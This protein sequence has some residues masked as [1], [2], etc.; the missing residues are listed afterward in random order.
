MDDLSQER[1]SWLPELMDRISQHLKALEQA[2]PDRGASLKAEHDQLDANVK[3]WSLTLANPNLAL[4]MRAV[5]EEQC[6]EVLQR[7]R[8][9]EQQ[10]RELAA[11]RSQAEKILDPDEVLGRLDKLADV[12]AS[13]NPT[14][15]NLE[16]SFHI[17]RI[18]CHA[19]GRIEV[20]T[21]QLGALTGACELMAEVSVGHRDDEAMAKSCRST[22]GFGPRRRTRLRLHDVDVPRSQLQASADFAADPY[23]FAGLGEQWFWLDVFQIPGK[24]TSWAEENAESVKS[25]YDEL[26]AVSG[27][28][29][30]LKVLAAEFG[31]SRPTISAALKIAEHGGPIRDARCKEPDSPHVDAKALADEFARLER[32]EGI[33]RAAIAKR[34][35]VH[36]NTVARVLNDWYAKR[37]IKP[38]DGRT[39]RWHK[40]AK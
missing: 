30:S 23:R 13:N 6:Q 16:L 28:K 22:D 8:Q 31:K 14:L 1:P 35:G 25:R 33:Q 11:I 3:G 12:L 40:S 20:R 37:G 32:E 19:D 15:G 18:D 27:K 34:F 21:C 36:R 9:I 29:P 10:L 4:E 24:T 26:A 38:Q 5:I 39:T 7:K 2:E 17:D